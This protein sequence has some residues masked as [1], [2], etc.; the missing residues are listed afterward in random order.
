MSE[1]KYI[2]VVSVYTQTTRV[3]LPD[4]LHVT[5]IGDIWV[6]WGTVH[7]ELYPKD[8]SPV[9]GDGHSAALKKYLEDGKV[10][11]V[12]TVEEHGEID[13]KRPQEIQAYDADGNQV[14][15]G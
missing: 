15:E 3:E 7:V 12:I 4:E 13:T 8:V 5:Q 1:K 2:D 9:S 6:K 10:P 11:E 14:F